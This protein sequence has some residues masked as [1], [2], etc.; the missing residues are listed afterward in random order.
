MTDTVHDATPRTAVRPPDARQLRDALGNFATGVIV[1]TYRSEGRHHGVTVNS[2]TSVSM[3]P[4]LV[5]V[6]IQR[7]SRALPYLLRLPFAV[8]VLGEDQLATAMRFA[9]RPQDAHH[10][11]WIQD[12]PDSAPRISGSPAYFQCTPWA[13][14]DGGDHVLI[15]GLVHSFGH[16][17]DSGPLLFHRGRWGSL[18]GES[19][20]RGNPA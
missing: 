18:A 16:T 20:G 11:P 7:T 2:F 14:Y 19:D 6:S 4:A 1:L 9:G 3:D 5:L 13:D 12:T 8:N 10:V 15:L 17:D